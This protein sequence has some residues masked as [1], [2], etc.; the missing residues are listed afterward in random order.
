MLNDDVDKLKKIIM[1]IEEDRMKN[2]IKEIIDDDATMCG[3]I[4]NII[5]GE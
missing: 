4:K 3:H 5:V 2:W 1:K